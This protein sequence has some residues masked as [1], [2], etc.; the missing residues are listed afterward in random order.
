MSLRKIN[1]QFENGNLP[2]DFN[3]FQKPQNNFDINK[4][5]YNAFYKEYEYHLNNLPVALHKLPGIEK[6][7]E[8]NMNL[9]LNTS[10]LEEILER[11]KISNDINIEN[12]T[13]LDAEKKEG[14]ENINKQ[15]E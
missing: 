7:V 13:I 15:I 9:S 1:E 2:D 10:P 12:S 3:F 4:I 6:I 8:H 14:N 11:Q 5:K